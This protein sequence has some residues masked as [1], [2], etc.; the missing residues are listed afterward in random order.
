MM[1]YCSAP[2]I[3]SERVFEVFAFPA[4]LGILS[5]VFCALVLSQQSFVH[6]SAVVSVLQ[7][8]CQVCL[9]Y[10]VCGFPMW[11]MVQISVNDIVARLQ[12]WIE[13]VCGVE[14]FHDTEKWTDY[15]EAMTQ[16]CNA[17]C[18]LMLHAWDADTQDVRREFCKRLV[19]HGNIGSDRVAGDHQATLF[20]P[21]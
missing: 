21:L 1:L 8:C 2:H 20:R 12:Y 3:T 9:V 16:R 11:A 4:S 5:R 17:E 10:W 19:R 18:S 14:L 13:D 15:I 6:V 7:K